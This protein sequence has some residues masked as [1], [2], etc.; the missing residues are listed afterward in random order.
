MKRH[1]FVVVMCVAAAI[2]GAVRWDPAPVAFA[3][4]QNRPATVNWALHNLDLAGTRY[5]PLDQ[6]N[7]S[8]VKSLTPRWLFQH[9]GST[10]SAIRRR[11]SWSTGSCT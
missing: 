2:V 6:I 4:G 10:A 3:Q 5:S 1:L 11:P 8:N 7:R 9:G